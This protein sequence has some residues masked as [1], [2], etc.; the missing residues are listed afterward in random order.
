MSRLKALRENERL[1]PP[2][3]K[4]AA[5]WVG[6]E[7]PPPQSA[8]LGTETMGPLDF[9]AFVDRFGGKIPGM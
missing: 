7:P 4:L 9:A 1:Y 5:A 8:T 2:L 6:Y 3:H